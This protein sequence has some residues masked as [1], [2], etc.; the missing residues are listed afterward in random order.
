[1]LWV[2]AQ[3][4]EVAQTVDLRPALTIALAVAL[5]GLVG[6]I[7]LRWQRRR[8]QRFFR[9]LR[10][11]HGFRRTDDPAQLTR[12]GDAMRS[13]FSDL[14]MVV[15]QVR[16][17]RAYECTD[18]ALDISV[19][20]VR[21]GQ[22][23]GNEGPQ[24]L[25]KLVLLVRGFTQ[26]LPEFSLYPGVAAHNRIGKGDV[27]PPVSLFAE[28]NMVVGPDPPAIRRLL[29]PQIQDRLIPNRDIAIRAGNDAVAFYPHG[30]RII[31]A[32]GWGFYERC[33]QLAELMRRT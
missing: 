27:F 6:G 20:H 5:I 12:L 4:D 32:D 25:D 19:V 22:D 2:L 9:M 23:R 10:E 3:V 1:M 33:L 21:L 13:L 8:E 30:A 31:P 15:R 24:S 7:V 11:E 29:N 18:P 17:V 16:V 14:R 26:T 28:H